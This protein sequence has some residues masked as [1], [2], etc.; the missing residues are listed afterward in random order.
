MRSVLCLAPFAAVAAAL[1]AAPRPLDAQGRSADVYIVNDWSK[2]LTVT[3]SD[4]KFMSK[5]LQSPIKVPASSKA[6]KYTIE[7]SDQGGFKLSLKADGSKE[8]KATIDLGAK[9]AYSFDSGNPTTQA[10]LLLAPVKPQDTGRDFD[11]YVFSGQ[12]DST[13]TINSLIDSKLKPALAGIKDKP[14][15]LSAEGVEVTIKEVVNPVVKSSYATL[16]WSGFNVKVNAIIDMSAEVKLTATFK[17]KTQDATVKIS[18]LSMLLTAAGSVTNLSSITVSRLQASLDQ[19]TSDADILVDILQAV[20]PEIGQVVK[21]TFKLASVA[22]TSENAKIIV[23]VN[24]AI[25]KFASG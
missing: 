3:T 17:G 14:V 4:N 7:S 21:N 15:K 11:F 5:G 10:G 2:S 19:L 6:S 16:E 20:Y 25:K 8:S 12:G 9:T 22:N 1:V 23:L 18:G 13:S 24:N